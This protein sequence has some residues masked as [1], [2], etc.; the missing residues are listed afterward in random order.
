MWSPLGTLRGG[1]DKGGYKPTTRTYYP[2]QVAMLRGGDFPARENTTR[3]T[4]HH[5]QQNNK[6][7]TVQ[8]LALFL[9]T[10]HYDTLTESNPLKQW[11][12]EPLLVKCARIVGAPPKAQRREERK[13]RVA[14]SGLYGDCSRLAKLGK[15]NALRC[16]WGRDGAQAKA[17]ICGRCLL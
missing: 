8:P 17:R 11:N 7:G 2:C 9:I 16:A 12:E 5:T 14:C 6:R 13:Q 10:P 4:L 15:C 3:T 1:G